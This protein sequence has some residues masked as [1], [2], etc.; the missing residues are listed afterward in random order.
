LSVGHVTAVPRV[1]KPTL[2]CM[3][4]GSAVAGRFRTITCAKMTKHCSRRWP[5]SP[6]TSASGILSTHLPGTLTSLIKQIFARS[7][8]VSTFLRRP[9]PPPTATIAITLV[10]DRPH[11]K[12]RPNPTPLRLPKCNPVKQPPHRGSTSYGALYLP[13]ILVKTH[14][15]K[16][17]IQP[18][19]R[20]NL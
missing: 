5:P 19:E 13:S 8:F 6:T 3:G 20:F 7:W 12:E 9:R 17:P 16:V 18:D 2:R 4:I 14:P 11:D 1:S 10:D 15:N